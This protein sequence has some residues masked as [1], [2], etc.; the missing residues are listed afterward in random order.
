MVLMSLFS[1]EMSSLMAASQLH[2]GVV[3]AGRGGQATVLPELAEEADDDDEEEDDEEED[4]EEEVD[5]EDDDRQGEGICFT[6]AKHRILVSLGGEETGGAV[7]VGGRGSSRNDTEI[8]GEGRDAFPNNSGRM[9]SRGSSGMPAE[10][11][12]MLT[13][14]ALFLERNILSLSSRESLT[15]SVSV[16]T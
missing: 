13:R 6:G 4:D 15:T 7:G 14:S 10:E 5:E 1:I 11:A 3:I 8:D 9:S 2:T 16:I 12:A